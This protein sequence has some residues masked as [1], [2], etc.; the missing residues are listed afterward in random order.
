MAVTDFNENTKAEIKEMI[1]NEG[2]Y[3]VQNF[4]GLQRRVDD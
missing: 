1:E 2:Y 4:H 3:F